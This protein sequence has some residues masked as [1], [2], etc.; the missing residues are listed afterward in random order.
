LREHRTRGIA[1]E[2]CREDDRYSFHEERRSGSAIV[3]VHINALR[4]FPAGV[5]LDSNAHEV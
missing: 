1:K 3:D 2:S 5:V 4:G